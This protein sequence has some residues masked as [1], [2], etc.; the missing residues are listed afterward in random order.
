MKTVKSIFAIAIFFASCAHAAVTVNGTVTAHNLGAST[1]PAG[2]PST[3]SYTAPAGTVG[4]VLIEASLPGSANAVPTAF[5]YNGVAAT[6]IPNT[7]IVSPGGEQ[8]SI[9]YLASPPTGSADTIS[10]TYGQSVAGGAVI[11]PVPLLGVSSTAPF[12]TTTSENISASPGTPSGGNTTPLVTPPAATSNDL[13]IGILS[14]DDNPTTATVNGGTSLASTTSRGSLFAAVS[15]L[16]G[17]GGSLGWTLNSD[18]N[19]AMAAVAF[20]APPPPPS[21]FPFFGV[22]AMLSP[23]PNREPANDTRMP[24][25]AAE[26]RRRAA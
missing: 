16:P 22:G 8:T 13:F 9:W 7:F 21:K 2:T 5:S 26:F 3:F 12:Q 17:N 11:T 10:I 14:A 6:L 15:S 20:L 23:L 19:W 24:I 18:S 1:I 25:V 4:L